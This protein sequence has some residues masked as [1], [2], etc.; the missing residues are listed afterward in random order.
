[1]LLKLVVEQA[2]PTLSQR[3]SLPP[4]S[5]GSVDASILKMMLTLLTRY[6][7]PKFSPALR[8]EFFSFSI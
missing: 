6:H 5:N 8:V 2:K 7:W 3:S 4:K 1:M